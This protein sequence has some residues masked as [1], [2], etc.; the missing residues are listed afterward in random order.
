MSKSSAAA[1]TYEVSKQD[2]DE[3]SAILS[4]LSKSLAQDSHDAVKM[5]EAV[6]LIDMEVEREVFD[7]LSGEVDMNEEDLEPMRV[8]E[9]EEHAITL[10]DAGDVDNKEHPPP[11]TLIQDKD[12]SERLFAFV[13]DNCAFVT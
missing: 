13:S 9:S 1:A 4:K 3:L 11:L 7:P 8:L 12:V 10:R 2:I 6:D 5:I